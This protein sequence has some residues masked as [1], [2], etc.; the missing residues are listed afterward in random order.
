MIVR[1]LGAIEETITTVF[2]FEAVR[3]KVTVSEVL[4]AARV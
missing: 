3:D 4:D 1:A 2:A